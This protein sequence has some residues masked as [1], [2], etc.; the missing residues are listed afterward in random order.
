MAHTSAAVILAAGAGRRFG[1]PKALAR[2]GEKT[3]LEIAVERVS[4]ADFG[5]ATIVLGAEAAAV[6]AALP[7]G[8][9]RTRATLSW[10]INT[11]WQAGRTG[12]IAAG[13]VDLRGWARG[14]LIYPVDFP[15]VDTETIYQL[16]GAFDATG[17]AEEKIILPVSGGRRGH[18]IIIGRQVWPEILALGRDDPLHLIVRRDA[19]RV[20][21]VAV[22]DAGIHRNINTPEDLEDP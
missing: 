1:G 13:L 4:D 8:D 12:S 3:W 10:V 19:A 6:R 7:A 14:A 5:W 9:S 15:V 11:E 20:V 2:R 22:N 17:E 18:P 21:E 16:A